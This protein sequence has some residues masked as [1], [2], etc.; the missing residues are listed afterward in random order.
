MAVALRRSSF[1]T[2]EG[3]LDRGSGETEAETETETER[4]R[5]RDRWH[6]RPEVRDTR[7]W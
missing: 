5:D 3:G 1:T 4:D 2:L 6:R 7:N